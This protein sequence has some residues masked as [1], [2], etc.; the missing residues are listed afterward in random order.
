MCPLALLGQ[1]RS[2]T[3]S[4]AALL[5]KGCTSAGQSVDGPALVALAAA[6]Q[7]PRCLVVVGLGGWSHLLGM[8]DLLLDLLGI[9]LQSGHCLGLGQE[10]LRVLGALLEQL[11]NPL[12]GHLQ[13]R[14]AATDQAKNAV[15]HAVLVQVVQLTSAAFPTSGDQG[16]VDLQRERQL[17]RAAEACHPT[18]D[19]AGHLLHGVKVGQVPQGQAARDHRVHAVDAGLTVQADLYQAQAGELHAGFAAD[20]YAGELLASQAH[21]TVANQ[22]QGLL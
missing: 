13:A 10:H 16:A 8:V 19:Q 3:T 18:G 4:Q 17:V 2:Q 15:Q 5:W 22:E 11:V 14:R 7:T 20:L 9:T 21:R 12:L 1:D 6:T